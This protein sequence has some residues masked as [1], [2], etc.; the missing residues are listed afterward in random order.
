MCVCVFECVCER[1]QKEKERS[2]KTLEAKYIESLNVYLVTVSYTS[3]V[4]RFP[5]NASLS[6]RQQ[7]LVQANLVSI[8]DEAC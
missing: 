4:T 7:K 6:T 3:C 8:F 5:Q 2:L 1:V